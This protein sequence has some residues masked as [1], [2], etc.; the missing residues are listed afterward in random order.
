MCVIV[1]IGKWKEQSYIGSGVVSCDVEIWILQWDI[2][3]SF[4]ANF[5]DL[6]CCDEDKKEA[7]ILERIL[8][9]YCRIKN[10]NFRISKSLQ[11]TL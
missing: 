3:S 11:K 8:C 4:W 6:S 5:G 9:R 1:I 10:L 2:L 7:S